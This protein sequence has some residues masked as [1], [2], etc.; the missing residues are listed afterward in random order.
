MQGVEYTKTDLV[1]A[2]APQTLTA[3]YVQL[4]TEE[5]NSR[6]Y[7]IAT[8]FLVLDVNASENVTLKPMATPG[9]TDEFDFPMKTLGTGK[10]L[11]DPLSYELNVDADQKIAVSIDVKGVKEMKYYIKAGTLG[12][13]AGIITSAYVVYS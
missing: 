9:S 8:L 2:A 4:G 5:L 12:A 7:E 6:N 1:L 3:S 11:L 13:T 10:V